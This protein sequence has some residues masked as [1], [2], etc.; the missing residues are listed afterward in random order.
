MH[1]RSLFLS[2]L[3]FPAL[4]SA[5]A[6]FPSLE[7]ENTSGNGVHVPSHG[8][9]NIVA[10]VAGKKAE[11]LLED[12]FAPA[13]NRFIMKSG[14]FASS[15]TVDLFLVPVFTGLDKA[16]YGPSMNSLKKKVDADLAQQV[17]FYKGDA[18]LVLDALGIKDKGIPYFFTVDPQGNIVHRESGSFSVEKLD[19]LEAPML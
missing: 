14:L 4:L 3:V 11:P 13:Y 7:G 8:R 9:W 5:Q 19:A 18:A 16:A 15:Y 12:W 2:A 17:V 1:L 6:G 10:V